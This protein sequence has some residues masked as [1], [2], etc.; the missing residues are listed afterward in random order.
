[1]GD[2]DKDVDI[3]R[4]KKVDLC[5]LLLGSP[6]GKLYQNVGPQVPRGPG[7]DLD[8]LVPSL[9][10]KGGCRYRKPDQDFVFFD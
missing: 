5:Y 1:M 4:K 7:E 2:H 8:V 10:D 6:R 3:A 9:Y